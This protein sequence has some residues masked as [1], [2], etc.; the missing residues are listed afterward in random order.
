[1]DPDYLEY[2]ET[3]PDNVLESEIVHQVSLAQ[4]QQLCS[5]SRRLN[6]LCGRD[7]IWQKKTQIDFPSAYAC[8]PSNL[9]WLSYYQQNVLQ[10]RKRQ[11]VSSFLDLVYS[12]YGEPIIGIIPPQGQQLWNKIAKEYA[13]I[14]LTQHPSADPTILDRLSTPSMWGFVPTDPIYRNFRRDV[15]FIFYYQHPKYIDILSKAPW[16]KYDFTL[17]L[18]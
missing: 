16:L 7:S 9:N 14:F 17:D 10:K 6:Q 15:D 13:N 12:K 8:K 2:L 3:L 5:S 1:M 18:K 4:I 11:R